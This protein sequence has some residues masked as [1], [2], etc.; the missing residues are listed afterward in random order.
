MLREGGR[1]GEEKGNTR[2]EYTR[3]TPISD[4]NIRAIAKA[5][6]HFV[7]TLFL[8]CDNSRVR[9]NCDTVYPTKY[10]VSACVR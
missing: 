10:E 7:E 1:E 8:A 6:A 5:R 4:D 2:V 3:D 9:E